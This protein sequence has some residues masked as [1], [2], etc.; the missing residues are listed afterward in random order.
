[1]FKKESPTRMALIV[2]AVL[3]MI[4]LACRNTQAQF[5]GKGDCPSKCRKLSQ[6]LVKMGVIPD[7]GFMP[8]C[9]R[10]CNKEKFVSNL[11]QAK[12]FCWEQ[13]YLWLRLLNQHRNQEASRLCVTSCY[14]YYLKKFR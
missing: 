10:T 4:G 14:K 5:Q 7:Q 13:C 6:E 11:Q 1:M 2:P 12:Q 9:V 8:R 3:I